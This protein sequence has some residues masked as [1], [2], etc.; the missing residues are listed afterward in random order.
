M[1]GAFRS[2]VFR[3]IVPSV[4]LLSYGSVVVVFLD[5]RH[6]C[7]WNFYSIIPV[8]VVRV[9]SY[10]NLL[11]DPAG[12]AQ[13]CGHNQGFGYRQ[14]GC[15]AHS[16]LC[17]SSNLADV[18]ITAFTGNPGNLALLSSQLHSIFQSY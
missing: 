6:P 3:C 5:H 18:D 9:K 11:F 15:L 13:C 8:D 10:V 17:R 2:L 12:C 7:F 4:A 1:T 14:F 16:V